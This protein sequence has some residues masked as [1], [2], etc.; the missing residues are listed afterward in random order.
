MCE[1]VIPDAKESERFQS[2]IWNIGKERNKDATIFWKKQQACLV[3]TLSIISNQCKNMPN[4]KE[5]L[6]KIAHFSVSKNCLTVDQD[7]E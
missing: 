3:I 4:W 6:F 2:D 7:P 5:T 1:N